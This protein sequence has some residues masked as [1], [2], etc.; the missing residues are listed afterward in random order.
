MMNDDDIHENT[1]AII[2]R[3]RR[4]DASWGDIFALGAG[5]MVNAC[6]N[7]GVSNDE[8]YYHIAQALAQR[9]DK[10]TAERGMQ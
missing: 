5:L 7:A 4:D 3:L 1:E 8:A 2:V 6:V 10:E 9:P